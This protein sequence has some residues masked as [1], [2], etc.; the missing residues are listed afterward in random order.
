MGL[1]AARAIFT[2]YTISVI[3][4]DIAYNVHT[5]N[6]ASWLKYLTNWNYILVVFYFATAF[7]ITGSEVLSLRKQKS[8]GMLSGFVADSD[9]TLNDINGNVDT[10]KVGVR[11]IVGGKLQEEYASYSSF[12]RRRRL[13][14]LQHVTPRDVTCSF[15][16]V[17][18][19]HNIAITMTA[20][21]VAGYWT[22][23]HDYN[24]ELAMDLDTFLKIDSHGINLVLLL[25]DFF[26]HKIPFRILHFIHPF[27]LACI[28]VIFH[29]IYWSV[30]E[31]TIYTATDWKNAP[32]FTVLSLVG[33]LLVIFIF[34]F[35][36]YLL[37]C[38]IVQSDCKTK[39]G[40]FMV[41]LALLFVTL[42]I[43]TFFI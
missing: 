22:V 30:T 4:I 25:I 34:H 15:K 41:L 10:G 1:V 36:L 39:I 9:Y 42:A 18:V 6:S 13:R 11:T 35:I 20:T 23:I 8:L 3:L 19:L 17:W 26:L 29:I 24:E 7:V 38:S 33:F 12:S 16:L 32:G 28:Y 2:L 31:D 27:L 43:L 40:F 21:I 37:Y 14:R 5:T